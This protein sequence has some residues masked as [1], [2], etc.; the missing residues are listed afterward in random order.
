MVLLY[1]FYNPPTDI[2]FRYKMSY[3]NDEEKHFSP[4]T[5]IYKSDTRSTKYFD[6]VPAFHPPT[7]IHLANPQIKTK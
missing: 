5:I 6:L 2:L 1:I 4:H 7:H 3:I